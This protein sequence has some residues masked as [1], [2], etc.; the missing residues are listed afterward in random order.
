M[1]KHGDAHEED[2][3]VWARIVETARGLEARC[4]LD[5]HK[6]ASIDRAGSVV[7][8]CRGKGKHDVHI[9]TNRRQDPPTS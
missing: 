1:S 4:P 8:R 5:G 3:S 7:V 2:A 6:L 9:V